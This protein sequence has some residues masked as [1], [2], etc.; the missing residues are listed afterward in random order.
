MS[1]ILYWFFLV[2]SIV[3]ISK[4]KEYTLSSRL[5]HTTITLIETCIIMSQKF[6]TK[7]CYYGIID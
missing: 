2:E 7:K 3:L 5:Y 4:K 6:S 1:S